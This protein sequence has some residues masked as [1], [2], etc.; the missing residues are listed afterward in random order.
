MATLPSTDI[1]NDLYENRDHY[2]VIFSN[3]SRFF[4]TSFHLFKSY[5]SLG[6]IASDENKSKHDLL[7]PLSHGQKHRWRTRLLGFHH[8]DHPAATLKAWLTPTL[9]RKQD[10]SP[11]IS[12]TIT[13]Y[14]PKE[15]FSRSK[16]SPLVVQY[17]PSTIPA[18]VLPESD[19]QHSDESDVTITRL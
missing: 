19:I 17:Q 5:V 13:G 18:I 6:Y 9:L 3:D 11:S 14:S 12:S 4:D 15:M 10:R 16:Q 8:H 1:N 7:S 2:Q